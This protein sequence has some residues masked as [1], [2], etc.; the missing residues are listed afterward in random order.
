MN[1]I[2]YSAFTSLHCLDCEPSHLFY[3]SCPEAF[4]CKRPSTP[5]SWK[6]L[7]LVLLFRWALHWQGCEGKV[8]EC[9]HIATLRWTL[10][11][12]RVRNRVTCGNWTTFQQPSKTKMFL[13]V[14]FFV[15]F[16]FL[17]YVVTNILKYHFILKR[18]SFFFFW[19]NSK[20]FSHL[21]HQ[22]S[23]VKTSK[24]S[25]SSG[26]VGFPIPSPVHLHS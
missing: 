26:G 12:R 11:Q 23:T 5:R 20:A 25:E 8:V 16:P 6:Q 1:K 17:C 9:C 13:K 10:E 7:Q 2:S 21:E 4:C 18:L 22:T 14:F 24:S 19:F 15:C 3:T